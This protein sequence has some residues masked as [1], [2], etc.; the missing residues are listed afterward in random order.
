[1]SKARSFVHESEAEL[2]GAPI[3]WSLSKTI[4]QSQK[5]FVSLS[6]NAQRQQNVNPH[7]NKHTI[8]QKK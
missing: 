8:M 3:Q 7:K 1:M 6:P 4:P 2:L 5:D